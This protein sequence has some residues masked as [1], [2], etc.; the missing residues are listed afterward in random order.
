M[1]PTATD[2]IAAEAVGHSNVLGRSFL[3]RLTS[4]FS[5]A[6]IDHPNSPGSDPEPRGDDGNAADNEGNAADND[7][8]NP[9]EDST[10]G[11]DSQPTRKAGRQ[12][13]FTPAQLVF[14]DKHFPAYKQASGR[15][16]PTVTRLYQT[17]ILPA[18]L[19]E[20]PPSEYLDQLVPPDTRPKPSF[21]LKG[22]SKGKPKGKPKGKSKGKSKAKNNANT[23][24]DGDEHRDGG[25]PDDTQDRDRTEGSLDE[26][27]TPQITYEERMYEMDLVRATSPY[28]I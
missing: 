9:S 23:T 1:A 15:S 24:L 26:S 11:P 6:L 10:A 16:R 27:T 22:R 4:L 3:S 14:F 17:T 2:G 18:W 19:D 5:H 13:Q 7:A 20:F 21:K 25:N 28:P 12:S 8:E